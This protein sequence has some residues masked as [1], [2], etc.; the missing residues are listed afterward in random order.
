MIEELRFADCCNRWQSQEFEGMKGGRCVSRE[1]ASS[2]QREEAVLPRSQGHQKESGTM[3]DSNSGS[4]NH[5]DAATTGGD[6]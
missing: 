5:G 1:P 2:G 4:W 3:E 6:A